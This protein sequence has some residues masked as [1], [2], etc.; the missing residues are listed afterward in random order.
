MGEIFRWLAYQI[1]TFLNTLSEPRFFVPIIIV[2]IWWQF[3]K[4]K[5]RPIK[6]ALLNEDVEGDK[7]NSN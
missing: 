5:K 6:G 7:K 3:A 1:W 2:V 4:R